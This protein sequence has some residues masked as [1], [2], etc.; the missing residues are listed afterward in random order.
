MKDY[1][2]KLLAISIPKESWSKLKAFNFVMN[3]TNT[4][5]FMRVYLNI[6]HSRYFCYVF[7]NQNKK[8]NILRP[9]YSCDSWWNEAS[10]HSLFHFHGVTRA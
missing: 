6:F 5:F 1:S 7:S 4:K 8:D 10:R 3:S 2:T 9:V